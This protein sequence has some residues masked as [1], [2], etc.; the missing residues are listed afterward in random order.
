[1]L[2]GGGTDDDDGYHLDKYNDVEELPFWLDD[3]NLR[4]DS[5]DECKMDDEE[6]NDE[7]HSAGEKGNDEENVTN[8]MEVRKSKKG[9]HKRKDIWMMK[10]IWSVYGVHC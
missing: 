10:R 4:K 5:G 6:N 9:S 1:M 8:V 3:E 7:D 2:M